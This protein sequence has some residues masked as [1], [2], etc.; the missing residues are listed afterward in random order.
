MAG[1]H[2]PYKQVQLPLKEESDP[3]GQASRQVRSWSEHST[4]ES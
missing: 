4:L 1:K 2:E 3:R